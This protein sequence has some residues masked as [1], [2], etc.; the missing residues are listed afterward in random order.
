[1]SFGSRPGRRGTLQCSLGRGNDLY[2]KLPCRARDKD[3]LA[4]TDP[5]RVTDPVNT[6]KDTVVNIVS[7]ADT[8]QIL[9]NLDHMIDPLDP[10]LGW[11]AR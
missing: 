1:M 3:P 6:S 5:V 2:R 9:S 4:G 11:G 10:P 8:K 7:L